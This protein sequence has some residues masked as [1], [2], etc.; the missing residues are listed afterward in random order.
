MWSGGRT[1]YVQILMNMNYLKQG[2]L[3]RGI[4]IWSVA[5]MVVPAFIV[6]SFYYWS[7]LTVYT[8]EGWSSD[9]K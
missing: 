5:A 2:N 1:I 8:R 6:L 3:L 7:G 9:L 4:D